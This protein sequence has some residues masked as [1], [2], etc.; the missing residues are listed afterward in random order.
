MSISSNPI[1]VVHAI[2]VFVGSVAYVWN[3][4]LIE[5]DHNYLLISPLHIILIM[6][7][8]NLFLVK[9][10]FT[11]SRITKIVNIMFSVTVGFMII[12]GDI[13]YH[14]LYE[15]EEQY[16]PHIHI[17]YIIIDA[18]YIICLCILHYYDCESIFLKTKGDILVLMGFQYAYILNLLS[19][20]IPLYMGKKI[21]ITSDFTYLFWILFMLEEHWRGVKKR[22][23]GLSVNYTSYNS[24]SNDNVST[25]SSNANSN[26]SKMQTTNNVI[27][28]IFSITSSVSLYL[29][30]LININNIENLTL[31]RIWDYVLLSCNILFYL[32]TLTS[33]R[34]MY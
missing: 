5:N 22:S 34:H 26:T 8:F 3:F 30:V 1:Q 2:L 6:F 29:F 24:I 14:L 31:R 12:W 10:R 23:N 15:E 13:I 33:F 28:V 19:Q 9:F 20:V 16:M 18:L 21:P 32:W 7:S 27:A 25:L 4:Y 17:Y 11:S